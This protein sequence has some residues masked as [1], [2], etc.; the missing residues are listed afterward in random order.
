M[1]NRVTLGLAVIGDGNTLTDAAKE[2]I[3]AAGYLFAVYYKRP[4][5]WVKHYEWN[6]PDGSHTAC[7]DSPIARFV[8]ELRSHH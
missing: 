1:A 8:D 3:R 4:C 5:L 6:A 7:P 2:A